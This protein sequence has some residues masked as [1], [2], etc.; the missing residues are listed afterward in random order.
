MTFTDRVLALKPGQ[1]LIA[2]PDRS[3]KSTRQL[4]TYAKRK[5]G[6]PRRFTVKKSGDE[7][8]VWRL[9]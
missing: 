4:V 6:Q 3:W 8:E 7:I 9:V 5:S 2:E 1:K